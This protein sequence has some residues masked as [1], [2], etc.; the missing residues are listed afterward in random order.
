MKRK[1]IAF[2]MFMLGAMALLGA[3][4]D[5]TSSTV[6]NTTTNNVVHDMVHNADSEVVLRP[7]Q[8]SSF[9]EL[10]I[11]GGSS[12]VVVF[13]QSDN[14]A[15]YMELQDDLF[16]FYEVYVNRGTLHLDRSNAGR[17]ISVD[18][19]PRVYIYAPYLTAINVRGAL[20]AEDWEAIITPSFSITS[21]GF[22]NLAAPL[23]VDTLELHLNGA[24]ELTFRGN[25][26]SAT[27][28][29]NGAG[30]I[31]AGNLQTTGATINL[32]GAGDII[33]AVSD[34]LDATL[35]GVGNIR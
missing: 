7:F 16:D 25:A 14:I 12:F 10:E 23:E 21:N 17:M 13:R 33:I 24:S 6:G 32:N 8:V 35:E 28:T 31:M 5:T 1:I 15:V 30:N 27:I 3:C 18:H 34:S 22:I 19:R 9:D 11:G 29:K 20:H 2:A 26:G 4:S